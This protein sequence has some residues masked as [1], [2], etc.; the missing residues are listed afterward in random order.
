MKP[1]PKEYEISTFEQLINVVDE[2]NI[3]SLTLD[4]A[5]WL[6]YAVITYKEF[7]DKYPKE[8]EGKTNW[9]I[10]KCAFIWKDDGINKLT[11]VSVLV[12]ETGEK[13]NINLDNK[14]NL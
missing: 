1:L 8:C 13:I 10:A 5:L 9:E 7:R 6:Q 2:K 12:K 11:N 14:E 4:L 3:E